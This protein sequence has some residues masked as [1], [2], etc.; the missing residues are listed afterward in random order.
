VRTKGAWKRWKVL[1]RALRYLRPYRKLAVISLLFTLFASI[2]SLAEPW[3]LAIMIDSVLGEKSPPGFLKSIFGSD[4]DVYVLLIFAA[5]L[6]FALT[7]FGGMLMVVTEYV[8]TKLD[9]RMVLDLRSDLFE[10]TQRLSLTFHDSTLTGQ[11]MSRINLQA[12]ALGDILMSFPPLLQSGLTLI[13]MFVIVFL[14]D[15]QVAVVSLVAV[16]FIYYALGLYGTRIVP[17]VQR[18]M[19]LEMR[20][21]SIVHEAMGMLRVIVSFGR[22]NYEH[23]KFRT[24]A[25][26]AVD[27]RV[28]LTVRQTAFSLAVTAATAAGT[29]LVLGFGAW[30]VLQ[31][32]ITVG[33]LTVLLS[34][35]AS[36]YQ[37]LEAI[38]ATLGQLHQQVVYLNASLKLLDTEPEVV[39]APDAINIGRAKGRIVFENVN[40]AYKGRKATLKDVSFEAKPGQR[41]AVVGPTGAGK[42]TLVS[43]L[44]R[45]YD[46]KQGRILMDGVDIRRLALKS[47]RNQ[48][49]VVL[50]EPLLF[51]ST[52]AANI[53]YGSLGA[54]M[55]QIVAA[56]K[57]ANA[58]DFIS[59]LPDGYETMVGERGAQLSG[60]ERQRIS[61]ARAFIKDAPILIM[62]EPTSSIDSRTE[63]V[64]L[65]ALDDLMVGRTSF[66]IAHRLAT[67]RGT[68]QI[69]VINHG[70]LVGKGTHDQLLARDGLYRQLYEAQTLGKVR[71]ESLKAPDAEEEVTAEGAERATAGSKDK[72]E[73]IRERLIERAIQSGKVSLRALPGGID[74]ATPVTDGSKTADGQKKSD[75]GH[76]AQKPQK[77]RSRRSPGVKR[78]LVGSEDVTCDLCGRVLL[79][80]EPTILFM[81]PQEKHRQKPGQ[82]ERKWV[83]ELCSPIAEDA[84]WK[85]RPAPR[86][87]RLLKAVD[88]GKQLNGPAASSHTARSRRDA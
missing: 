73:R 77:S 35:I 39:E 67:I 84:G 51:S 22:E 33:E 4:P 74:D 18:V 79:K 48:V 60:G 10:H 23:R 14:I 20:S 42:T 6:G 32:K 56:A 58:H 8:N 49:S 1:P 87:Q 21:L 34:Y 30:H 12:R 54:D 16:P 86:G 62:D 63:S 71:P 53:Q 44:V 47:L 61:I 9:Q 3:P 75:N 7:I 76:R 70:K 85:A 65:D 43:L 15:W 13:G 52:I 45:F 27:E 26:T 59:Q 38:S 80:G 46:P 40:F 29:G 68:D 64:I 83:C 72:R 17:R 81:A 31:G 2:V 57:A 19:S 28:K 5:G 55:D 78:L 69:L 50:Q 36:V 11:L 88:P 82:K 66:L 37:P 24:Q 41:I 25:E